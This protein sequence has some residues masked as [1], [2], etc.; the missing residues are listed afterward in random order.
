MVNSFTNHNSI[1]SI[2]VINDKFILVNAY[3]ELQ[4]IDLNTFKSVYMLGRGMG[5]IA[6]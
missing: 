5:M 2:T 1:Y 3:G 4:V 6:Y